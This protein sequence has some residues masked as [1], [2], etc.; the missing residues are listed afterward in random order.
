MALG[1]GRWSGDSPAVAR[2]LPQEDRFLHGAW[3]LTYF[4][5]AAGIQLKLASF[6]H[7]EVNIPRITNL[8][9]L[10]YA[11]RTGKYVLDDKRQ[12]ETFDCEVSSADVPAAVFQNPELQEYTCPQLYRN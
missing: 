3:H 11:M 2:G 12:L 9:R 7:T 1:E 8:T 6:A 5:P 10:E 4:L